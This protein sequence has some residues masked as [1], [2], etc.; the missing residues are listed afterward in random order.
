MDGLR[1][2]YSYLVRTRVYSEFQHNCFFAG[3]AGARFVCGAYALRA[4]RKTRS[5]SV[6]TLLFQRVCVSVFVICADTVCVV[7]LV[8]Q[9]SPVA[10]RRRRVASQRETSA[11]T[12]PLF[13]SLLHCQ[14]NTRTHALKIQ[15]ESKTYSRRSAVGA[16]ASRRARDQHHTTTTTHHHHT[17]TYTQF[18]Q[19][20]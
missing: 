6:T 5:V 10:F 17:D 15:P 16:F 13:P 19:V 8:E 20:H 4:F 11:I 12:N 7:Q 18:S 2:V 1:I 9:R 14:I 3:F